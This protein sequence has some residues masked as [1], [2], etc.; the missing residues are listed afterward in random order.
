MSRTQSNGYLNKQ[1]INQSKAS[2]FIQVQIEIT[3]LTV[4][5]ML[6]IT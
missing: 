5:S 3:L 6:F 2:P 4:P 1:A